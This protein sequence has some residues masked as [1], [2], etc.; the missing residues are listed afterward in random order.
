MVRPGELTHRFAGLEFS[1]ILRIVRS[2]AAKPLNMAEPFNNPRPTANAKANMTWSLTVSLFAWGA[3]KLGW[4]THSLKVAKP[5]ELQ[6]NCNKFLANVFDFSATWFTVKMLMPACKH[7]AEEE[8]AAA[9]EAEALAAWEAENAAAA[10]AE[11]QRR[12]VEEAAAAEEEAAAAEADARAAWG[13]E[14][15]AAD[16]EALAAMEAEAADGAEAR[17]ASEAEAETLTGS[18]IVSSLES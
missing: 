11:Q 12:Q 14:N 18:S 9:A 5:E 7:L 8:A 13:A 16:A 10:E 4:R 17:V 15:T 2:L 1:R 3:F 6:C